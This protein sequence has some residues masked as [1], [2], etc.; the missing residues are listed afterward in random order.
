MTERPSERVDP[1]LEKRRDQVKQR[2]IHLLTHKYNELKILY[3]HSIYQ[4]VYDEPL[5]S[6]ALGYKS[7]TEMVRS[8]KDSIKINYNSPTVTISAVMK[9]PVGK[10]NIASKYGNSQAGN[11]FSDST[12]GAS[13]SSTT[14][15]SNGFD[16]NNKENTLPLGRARYNAIDPFN[17]TTM[18]QSLEPLRKITEPPMGNNKLEDIVKYRTMR[19]IFKDP[20][21]A[22]K[23]DDWER[24][25]EQEWNCTNRVRIRDYGFKTILE[26]FKSLSVELPFKIRLKDDEWVAKCEY[27]TLSTWL[28]NQVKVGKYR[29]VTVI[30]A[31]Y[32]LIAFPGDKYSYIDFE[33]LQQQPYYGIIKC[34]VKSAYKMCLQMGAFERPEDTITF[35]TSS[36]CYDDY[37][38]K[39][40]FAIP[41][42]FIK[43]GFPC[44]AYDELEQRWCRV[45]V[46]DT[47]EVLSKKTPVTAFLV[48][49]AITK[50]FMPQN[51]LCIL[52]NHLK[53]PV[54]QIQ[55]INN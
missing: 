22:L 49:Y 21:T 3:L 13:T 23:L 29:A 32:E 51:M 1:E 8:F 26:F 39:G 6:E 19:I 55:P 18:L 28:T 16:I 25:Y 27:E 34:A 42:G 7:L 14:P 12:H 44:A 15:A 9:E 41:E 2:L 47:P 53:H 17:V 40:F 38:R 50:K 33:S 45:I 5:S 10:E 37:K 30:D 46:V 52:K 35:E 54:S 11:N 24:R 43:A 48:D 20:D 31:K 36:S 4:T